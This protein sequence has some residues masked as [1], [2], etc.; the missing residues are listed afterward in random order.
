M[1][2]SRGDGFPFLKTSWMLVVFEVPWL[3]AESLL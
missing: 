3:G 1:V 2:G